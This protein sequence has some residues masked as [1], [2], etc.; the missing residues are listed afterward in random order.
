MEDF[1]LNETVD[2][3][4]TRVLEDVKNQQGSIPE[5][6]QI[7]KYGRA[8]HEVILKGQQRVEDGQGLSTFFWCKL[9]GINFKEENGKLKM[10]FIDT[11]YK[12]E[13]LFGDKGASTL[14]RRLDVNFIPP[15]E[16]KTEE[17][18]RRNDP[19]AAEIAIEIS[20]ILDRLDP[21]TTTIQE[22]AD[23]FQSLTH[24]TEGIDKYRAEFYNTSFNGY[25]LRYRKVVNS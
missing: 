9:I 10:S 1:K 22:Y 15:A 21:A 3:F 24:P 19:Y 23:R 16:K 12:F 5:R 14:K 4:R 13:D 17:S 8:H 11:D 20:E 7:S 18:D 6:I 25:I 2:G